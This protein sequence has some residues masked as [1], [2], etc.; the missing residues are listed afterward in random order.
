MALGWL[1]FGFWVALSVFVGFSQRPDVFTITDDCVT[2]YRLIEILLWLFLLHV[3]R[4]A[5]A[6]AA[7]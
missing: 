5:A 7:D 4:A 6:A 2:D 3:C 1:G